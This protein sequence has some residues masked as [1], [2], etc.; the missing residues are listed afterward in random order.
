MHAALTHGFVVAFGIAAAFAAVGAV[1]AAVG[2]PQVSLR[3]LRR[4][5]IATEGA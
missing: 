3:S 4:Q 2:L 1:I 5:A